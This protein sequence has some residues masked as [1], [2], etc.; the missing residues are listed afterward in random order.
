MSA[1]G[2]E[3]FSVS[4]LS[5]IKHQVERRVTKTAL[6]EDRSSVL[7]RDLNRYYGGL[8][9][10][11]LKTLRNANFSPEERACLGTLFMSTAFMEPDHIPLLV[12]SLE[13]TTDEI[14]FFG[15]DPDVLLA[16]VRALDIA[17]L[18]ALVD[19]IERDPEMSEIARNAQSAQ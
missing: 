6:A 10:Q 18:Y 5:S 11:G 17:A 4:M 1:D 2:Y 8:L 12:A 14:R 15:V 16:K 13:D 3:K 7:T 19:L 9:K